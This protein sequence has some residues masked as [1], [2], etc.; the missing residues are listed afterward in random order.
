MSGGLA[1]NAVTSDN[2]EALAL[3]SQMHEAAFSLQNET[4]WSVASFRNMLVS[5]G[6]SATIYSSSAGPVGFALIRTVLDEAEIITISVI[7][8]KQNQ[9]FG[10]EILQAEVNKLVSASVS[11]VFLEVRKDNQN[12]VSL[13]KSAGFRQFSSRENYYKLSTGQRVDASVYI[14][15]L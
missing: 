4:P 7:P 12:A 9:G 11:K 1:A 13:Y 10:A 14:L 3:L 5:P 8:E 15:D 6:V 2:E